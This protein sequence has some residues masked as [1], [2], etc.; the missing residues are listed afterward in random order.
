M[1]KRTI[2]RGTCLL[3]VLALLSG[4]GARAETRRA[5]LAGCNYYTGG[6]SRLYTSIN[7]IQG[8]RDH[9]LC[10]ANGYW[11]GANVVLLKDGQ[12]TYD[13]VRQEL[14]SA[15]QT[16]QDGDVFCFMYSGHGMSFDGSEYICLYDYDYEDARLGTDLAQFSGGVKI[17]II[18]DTCFSGGMFK[19][20]GA[21]SEGAQVNRFAERVLAAYQAAKAAAPHGEALVSKAALGANLA[22]MTA[23]DKN[24]YSWSYSSG[25]SF[26]TGYLVEA[27]HAPATDVNG[28]GAVTFQE[29]HD[30]AVPRVVADTQDDEVQTPQS[31]H[32]EVLDSIVALGDPDT[33]R[34]ESAGVSVTEGDRAAT[35]RLVREGDGLRAVSVDV[36]TSGETAIPG[37]DFTALTAKTVAW[38]A[39]DLTP[40]SVTVTIADDALAEGSETFWALCGNPKSAVLSA[41]EYATLVTVR[42]DDVGVPGNVRL[43]STAAS[44][45]ESAGY[46][47]VAVTRTGGSDGAAQV[48]YRTVPGTAEAGAD[49][50]ATEGVLTW[51]A[52]DGS[53]RA[54]RVPVLSDGVWEENESFGVELYDATGAALG[55]PSAATVTLANAG[56]KKSP[57]KALL[58]PAALSVSEADGVARVTVTREGGCDGAVEVKVAAVAGTAKAG[59]NYVATN[60]VLRWAHGDAAPQVLDV[61]LLDDGQPKPDLTFKLQLSAYK[62]GLSGVSRGTETPVTL[63][64]ATAT[65]TLAEA[66][67]NAEWRVTSGGTGLWCGQTEESADGA[68][69]ARLACGTIT[70]GRDAWL[71]ATVKGPGLI[72]FTWCG[73]AQDEDALQFYVGSAVKTQRVGRSDWERVDGVVVPSGSQTVK[74]RFIRNSAATDTA[75]SA[76]VDQVVWQPDAA[77]PAGP[78]P[79]SGGALTAD[80]QQVAWQAAPGASAYVVYLGASS[81]VQTQR[82]GQ[83]AETSLVLPA[84]TLGATYYWRVDAVSDSGRVTRGGVWRFK[85]PTGALPQIERPADQSVTV[86]VP[87]SLTLALRA[88]SPAAAAYSV[89]GLPKGLSVSA[90]GVIGGRPT[91]IGSNVVTVAASNGFGSGPAETFALCVKALPTAMAGSFAGLSGLGAD[92]AGCDRSL[93]GAIQMTVSAAGAISGSVRLMAETVRFSGVFASDEAGVYF[94]K[95]FTLKSGLATTLRVWPYVDG[96]LAQE[97]YRGRLSNAACAVDLAL[98]RNAWS[99]NRAALA[100]YAGYYTVVLPP[101][102]NASGAVLPQGVGYLTVKVEPTGTATAAGVLADGTSWSGS[103]PAAVAP[104]GDGLIVP[105]FAALYKGAGQLWGALRLVPQDTGVDDNGVEPYLGPFYSDLAVAGREGL[106]WYSAQRPESRLYPDG[107]ELDLAASGGAYN[108]GATSLEAVIGKRDHL[109]RLRFDAVSDS[110]SD[111]SVTV[112]LS[113]GTAW[114][115]PKGVMNPCG[116]TFSVRTQTGLFS[117]TFTLSDTSSGKTVTR[118]VTYKGALSPLTWTF[119]DTGYESPGSG[120]FT[121]SGLSPTLTTSRVDSLAAQLLWVPVE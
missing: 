55:V 31:F 95:A 78:Q 8:L 88:G 89:K 84:L 12:A 62:G 25:Y 58:A 21:R 34:M 119:G 15:A 116:A 22:F 85:V 115:P 121:V 24:E 33:I 3:A 46:V 110:A 104:D 105:V 35:V 6:L 11:P 7:D 69:A 65:V 82:L 74:W 57:G 73:Q 44:A 52:G 61:V 17:I 99:E 91:S 60:A 86:G 47:S 64:D 87:L 117:G 68:D 90:A 71:Q 118:R 53:A 28:D 49:F 113:G 51:G 63:R 114:L 27:A 5:L 83:T 70:K 103:A 56:T 111:P 16:C 77:K 36:S 96:A 102:E 80:P 109:L 20:A 4:V 48:R 101:G 39:G 45:S 10:A 94:E 38:A 75:A 18:F 67:D 37:K 66:L 79:A 72:A 32:P 42:D 92:E 30:Y 41:T 120:F 43:A 97:G 93:S 9:V 26:Y 107:F 100:A 76:G 14:A 2:S 1:K 13:R 106:V 29:L 59:V 81:S 50:L 108:T 40:K 112:A 19:A 23:S 98:T 54:I